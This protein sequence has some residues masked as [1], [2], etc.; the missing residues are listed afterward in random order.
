MT[1]SKT[2]KMV[3]AEQTLAFVRAAARPA[4]ILEVGCGDGELAL[5]LM[6]S[7]FQVVGVD[8]DSDAVAVARGRGIDAVCADFLEFDCPPI[9]AILFSRSLHHIEDPAAAV[10]HARDLLLPAGQ[11][12]VEDF[13]AGQVDLPAATW[14]YDVM[15][16]AAE[17]CGKS[18]EP[19]GDPLATWRAA[20]PDD[21]IHTAKVLDKAIRAV[22]KIADRQPAPY[23]YRYVAD[24]VGTNGM[25]PKVVA[26]IMHWEARLVSRGSLPGVG[27]RWHCR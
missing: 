21:H 10:R 15:A 25:A 8:P 22:F 13:D 12:F 14:L 24:L 9:E 20:H 4:T 16:V 3:G 1:T 18:H 7:G 11:L 17:I 2:A 5:L 23:L 19:V 26:A 27:Q 6:G